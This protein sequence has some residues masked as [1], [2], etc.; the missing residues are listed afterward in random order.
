MKFFILFFIL[1]PVLAF[2]ENTDWQNGDLIFQTSASKQSYAIMWASK[3]LYSHVG[4]VEVSGNKKYVIEAISKVSRTPLEKW[5]QRGRLKRYSVYRD[6]SLSE[7]I[8]NKIVTTA[9]TYLGKPYDIFFT[10]YNQ[11]IYCS[12]LV[13]LVYQKLHL[14]SGQMQKVKTLDVNNSIVKKLVE[15]RWRRHPVCKKMKN[16]E[17]CWNK[18][19]D[20]ELVTPDS[21][22]SDTQFKKVWS[23]YP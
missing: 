14:S 4:I 12:E 22:A 3:S 1:F 16:F 9:K 23:N 6:A 7:E 8:R 19:L 15:Q 18:I 20:D 13:Y 17:Q 5:I 21:I 11:E 2:A 10:S